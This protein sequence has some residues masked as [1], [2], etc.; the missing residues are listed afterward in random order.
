[1]GPK[2]LE[3]RPIEEVGFEYFRRSFTVD[4]PLIHL[5]RSSE[6]QNTRMEGDSEK[7]LTLSRRKEL[8]LGRPP[9][10]VQKPGYSASDDPDDVS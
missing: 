4:V 10:Y 9:P 6:F 7:H 5:C 8:T 1:M 2:I 3:V